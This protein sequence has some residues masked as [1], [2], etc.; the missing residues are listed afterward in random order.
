MKLTEHKFIL[1]GAGVA[2]LGLFILIKTKGVGGVVAPLA[3]AVGEGAVQVVDAATV[4]VVNG[5]SKEIGIPT[6]SDMITDPAAA[7][8]YRD[9]NGWWQAM[10]HMSAATYWGTHS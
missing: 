5:I 4:G 7:Q 2:A 3:E 8:A 6:T 10:G 9:A 1:I